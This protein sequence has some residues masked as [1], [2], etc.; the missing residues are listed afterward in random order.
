MHSACPAHFIRF[1]FVHRNNIWPEVKI[2]KLLTMQFS[3]VFCKF[4]PLRPK[5]LPHHPVIDQPQPVLFPWCKRQVSYTHKTTG[6]P[7]VLN[8]DAP[9]LR[10]GSVLTP[11][12]SVHMHRLP[13]CELVKCKHGSNT[14]IQRH[15]KR[16]N[17]KTEG[18]EATL[19]RAHAHFIHHLRVSRAASVF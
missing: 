19:A 3:P 9:W 2:L 17:T 18:P 5:L 8:A 16:T 12:P 4:C 1:L 13:T 10:H 15:S 14:K 6:K 11:R 7:A